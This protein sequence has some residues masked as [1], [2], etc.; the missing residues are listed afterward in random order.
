MKMPLVPL[1]AAMMTGIVVGNF[2]HIP[3]LYSAICLLLIFLLLLIA[4]LK[5]LTILS[6]G[7][8]MLSVFFIAVLNINLYVHRDY[9]PGHISHYVKGDSV[10]VEGVISETPENSPDKTAITVS[11]TRII[12]NGV[13]T[14]IHGLVLLSIMNSQP[15]KYGDYV[16][17]RTRLKSPHNFNNPGGFDYAKHLRYRDITVRGFVND[18]SGIAV[19]RENQGNVIRTYIET[20]RWK[21]KKLIR[22]NSMSPEGEIIQAMILGDQK[23]IPKD[24]MEKF[25]KTG[26]THIIAISGFNVGIIAALSIIVARIIMTFSTYLL[27]R[28]NI[29]VATT[30]FAII[31]VV[32]YTFIA[33]A[34]MSVVRAAIMAVTFMI[35]IIIGKE[36]DLYNTL[37]LAAFIILAISPYALFDISFQLSFVAVWSILFCTPRLMEW[38]PKDRTD[39]ASRYSIFYRKTLRNILI[40]I[41]VSLSATLGTLPLIV[42][43]FN[44][45]STI[46]LLSNV[47]VVPVLGI[48]AIPVST[49]IIAAALISTPLAVFFIHVSSFLVWISVAMVDFL[50]SIPGSSFFISTPTLPEL[51]L[52][53]CLLIAGV[54]LLDM[55][56]AKHKNEDMKEYTTR[57]SIIYG[58][59]FI[60][61]IFL[62][63]VGTV[64]LNMRDLF[65]K[66]M[67]VTAID[68]GQGSSILIQLPAG[69]KMLIDGGGFPEGDF[70]VGKYV[71]AP[72]LWHER[73]SKIDIVVLTHPHPDHL[74]GLLYILSN[75]EVGEVWTNGDAADSDNYREFL[76]IIEEKK[77]HHRSVSETTQT[78]IMN[79]V[80]IEILNPA[81]IVENRADNSRDFEKENNRSIVMRIVYKDISFL[82]PGDISE[83]AETRLAHSHRPM[84]SQ[85]VF[86]PH[87]GGF[88]SSSEAFLRRM[89]P[90]I[91][92]VNCGVDNIY[93]FP[94]PEVLKRYSMLGTKIFRTDKNGAVDIVTNGSNVVS[95]PFQHDR[96]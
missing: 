47:L 68:V 92:V 27:L 60:V 77:I 51:A 93:K 94:H 85:I 90:E 13:I 42:F 63:L 69:R 79:N 84:R 64:Y 65:E 17:F 29:H 59:A 44:R 7:L 40:F 34:G 54:K 52:Y 72:F 10:I 71:V 95:T 3:N 12:R 86:I 21:L 43:Y 32:F 28:F 39:V 16:R 57:H 8:L 11:A 61:L 55:R 89:L 41:I 25:N 15:F 31:T 82:F 19:L 46:V 5:N 36:R 2:I 6:I 88:T 35:A 53:Y 4:R 83:A 38:L 62:L 26:T 22:D 20:F 87:H 23:E 24:V 91:A 30:V 58:T 66:N 49:A 1:L 70:D 96:L 18:P 33:G 73:I 81:E 74:N 56:I 80:M 67:K 75:F 76:N 37:A 45:I 50:A 78:L 14:P 9:E 48:I